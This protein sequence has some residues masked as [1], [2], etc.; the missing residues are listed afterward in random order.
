MTRPIF[1]ISW[2]F[3]YQAIVNALS[4]RKDILMKQLKSSIEDLREIFEKGIKARHITEPFC[5]FDESAIAQDVKKFLNTKNFDVV[6][7]RTNGIING[8]ACRRDL[9]EGKLNKYSKEFDSRELLLD[10]TSISEVFKVIIDFNHVFILSFGRVAGIITRGDFQKVP[11]RMWLFSLISLIEMQMLR[12][13]RER[14][15]ENSWDESISPERNKKVKKFFV[16]NES[17]NEE[18][19]LVDCLQF[20]DKYTIISETEDLLEKLQYGKKDFCTLLKNLRKLR[21]NLAHAQDIITANWPS[22]I[23]L[24]KEAEEFL[25]RCET[26][27]LE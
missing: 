1:L 13:I 4:K 27:K 23:E 2:H 8:Y 21:D 6:G 10:T 19:D 16:D 11:I 14:F 18:I 12:I 26:I 25:K 17:K 24:S 5:S 3:Q 20:C 9:T 22:I 7:V 15:P